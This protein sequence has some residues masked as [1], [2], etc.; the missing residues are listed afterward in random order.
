MGLTKVVQFLQI[1]I[2]VSAVVSG[3]TV[4]A[5]SHLETP[6]SFAVFVV[7][8]NKTNDEAVGGVAGTAFFISKNKA[9]TAHHVLQAESFRPAAGFEKVRVW[10]VHEDLPPI[11]LKAENVT[12]EPE[13]DRATIRIAGSVS[14]N[15]IYRLR[16]QA[17]AGGEVSTEGFRANTAGPL[18]ARVGSDLAVVSVPH[19]DRLNSRGQLLKKANVDLTAADVKL[20]SIP[21]LQVSYLP[22]RGLSGGPV[23][24]NGQVIGM[25]SFADPTGVNRTWAVEM[26]DR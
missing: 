11:E 20:K 9:I 16:T 15:F 2:A 23:L 5:A 14:K 7:S 21:C 13:H 12:S 26:G 22:V 8:Y 10:L 24:L 6:K 18:L 4:S 1:A 3:V 17:L 25:N 19:L